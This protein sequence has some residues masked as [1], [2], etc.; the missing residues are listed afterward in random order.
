MYIAPPT[1][2]S[3]KTIARHQHTELTGQSNRRESYVD[4]LTWRP[5]LPDGVDAEDLTR[6][7]DWGR[8]C[9]GWRPFVRPH[10]SA[11]RDSQPMR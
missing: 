11:S 6:W 10:R 1:L 5:T 9:L 2:A 8:T 4:A 7:P 3:T